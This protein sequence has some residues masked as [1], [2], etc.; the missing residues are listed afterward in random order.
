MSRLFPESYTGTCV[1]VGAYDGVSGSNTYHFEQKGWKALCIEP[2]PTQFTKCKTTRKICV[3]CCVGAQYMEDATFQVYDINGGNE[4]AISS[5]NPD[6][7]LIASHSHMI[8]STYTIQVKVYTLTDILDECKF[9]TYI[10]FISVDTENTELDVLKGFDFS[11]YSVGY[12]IIEN[13]YDEPFCEDYLREHGYTKIHR[14]GVND[15]Y[16]RLE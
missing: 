3:N 11:K 6:S 16:K 14:T 12:F 5:L 2:N 1:E 7:R 8:G 4:S 13:N 15:I 9:P 10:D